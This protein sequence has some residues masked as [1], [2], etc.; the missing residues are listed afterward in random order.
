MPQG[1]VADLIQF[2]RKT[3]T[4]ISPLVSED[5]HTKHFEKFIFYAFSERTSNPDPAQ[6]PMPPNPCTPKNVPLSFPLPTQ[7]Y[8][9]HGHPAAV[10]S[11]VW[12]GVSHQF[13]WN[14]E[15]NREGGCK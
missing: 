4:R 7:A 2:W 10:S 5:I 3:Q 11:P 8:I 9:C 6:K 15:I 1:K 14:N 13:T 12:P